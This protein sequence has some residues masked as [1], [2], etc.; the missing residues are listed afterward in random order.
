MFAVVGVVVVLLIA[1]ALGRRVNAALSDSSSAD[2]GPPATALSSPEDSAPPASD[3]P[4]S[5]SS[6]AAS[7]TATEAELVVAAE[8]TGTW[9]GVVSQP[10]SSSDLYPTTTVLRTGRIGEVVGTSDYPTLGCSGNLRLIVGGPQARVR[11]E[12]TA[13]TSVSCIDGD[14]HLSLAS[15]GTLSWAFYETDSLFG[16]ADEPTATAALRRA[17]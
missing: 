16:D 11:E 14:I 15:D 4:G 9:Q 5:T 7:G 8:M 6:P 3:P 13:E 10:N 17:P 1:I 12:I 2:S